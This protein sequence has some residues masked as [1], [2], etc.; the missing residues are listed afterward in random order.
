MVFHE[1]RHFLQLFA[2]KLSK[3]QKHGSFF[4][5]LEGFGQ[6]YDFSCFFTN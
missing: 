6:M 2:E 1:M 4:E 3:A 5:K